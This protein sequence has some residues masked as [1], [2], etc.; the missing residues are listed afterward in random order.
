MW[1]HYLYAVQGCAPRQ[2]SG[3]LQICGQHPLRDGGKQGACHT[4]R[5]LPQLQRLEDPAPRTTSMQ[6]STTLSHLR[7]LP[8]VGSSITQVTLQRGLGA[9]ID[10]TKDANL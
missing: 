10:H 4:R 5:Q 1:L 6:A 7:H 2:Q 3:P 9:V 8:T